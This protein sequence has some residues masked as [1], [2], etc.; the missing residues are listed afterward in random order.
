MLE[1]LHRDLKNSDAGV[2]WS[3]VAGKSG[4]SYKKTLDFEQAP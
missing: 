4:S 1:V 3:L 2:G